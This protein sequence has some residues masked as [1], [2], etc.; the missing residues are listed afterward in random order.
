MEL[1]TNSLTTKLYLWFYKKQ[2]SE[3]PNSLCPYFW[4]LLLMW[5]LILP[6][7][8]FLL[9]SIIMHY[10]KYERFTNNYLDDRFE[11]SWVMYT[12]LFCVVCILSLLSIPWTGW[13]P[14]DNIVGL[15]HIF[16]S[17][18]TILGVSILSIIGY[19]SYQMNKTSPYKEK[20]PSIIVEFIKAKYNKYCPKIN[21]N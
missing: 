12:V 17:M 5:I 3:L 13:S 10:I 7:S 11:N 6:V 1:K 4:Q 18:F 19:D 8:L 16:G 2:V 9:P 14:K 21:W 20:R 15:L